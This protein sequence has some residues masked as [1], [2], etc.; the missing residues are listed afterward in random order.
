MASGR[1]SAESNYHIRT[2]SSQSHGRAVS[3][4]HPA[5]PTASARTSSVNTE[6]LLQDTESVMAAIQARLS[7][8]SSYGRKNSYTRDCDS[9]A[10]STVAL[11]NGE[12]NYVKSA[13]YKSPREAL[14]QI[15]RNGL[16]VKSGNTSSTTAVS[17]GKKP[18]IRSSAQTMASKT[19]ASPRSTPS[20]TGTRKSIVSDMVSRR[21]SMDND[22]IISDVSSDAGDVFA[23]SSKGK[24]PITMTRTNKT[25]DLRRARVDSFEEPAAPRSAKSSTSSKSGASNSYGRSQ[26]LHSTTRSRSLVN[27]SRSEAT[28][29]G[30]QIVKKSQSNIAQENLRKA[31]NT[32]IGRTDN[33]KHNQGK[34]LQHSSSAAAS[35]AAVANSHTKRE[36]TPKA[37]S[38]LTPTNKG[39][40]AI[41]G[42]SS[43]SSRS[44][45]QPSSRSNSPKAAEKMAW[46]RRKEY[47][48][49]KSVADAKA[50]KTKDGVSTKSKASAS[51]DIKKRM[52]RSA[53]FTNSAGLSVGIRNSVSGSQDF[54]DQMDSYN[55][56]E[57]FRRAFIPF[58]SSLRNDRYTHSADE[59]DSLVSTN[60]TQVFTVYPQNSF[61][62]SLS[63]L[64][65]SFVCCM[66]CACVQSTITKMHCKKLLFPFVCCY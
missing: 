11:V 39:S 23:R 61:Q 36:S 53:S 15:Q 17:S 34:K 54:T 16:S 5:S 22:S 52:T 4:G 1:N 48:A 26:S 44:Q 20:T 65:F 33:V 43:V 41:S 28:S 25:F 64:S 46:K 7:H 38:R 30:A 49:R 27:T 66:N 32:A 42:I 45:S 50:C 51:F 8:K 19:I 2:N 9:D 47:D 56:H 40:L 31:G 6:V 58:H 12:E 18:V 13:Q 62:C 35:H 59:D 3:N 55:Q 10:S 37:Q 57:D 60:S 29:L 24:A 63:I 21:D 14:A